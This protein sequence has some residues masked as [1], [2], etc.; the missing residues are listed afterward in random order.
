MFSWYAI[1][2]VNLIS[3]DLPVLEILDVQGINSFTSI[4]SIEVKS[5]LATYYFY[6]YYPHSI[7]S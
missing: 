5:R 6:Y 7:D 2:E 4:S 3:I 1:D